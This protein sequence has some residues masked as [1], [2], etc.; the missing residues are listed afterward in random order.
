MG[1][2]S[3]GAWSDLASGRELS[4]EFRRRRPGLPIII[5]SGYTGG[6]Y[7]ALEALPLG[8]GYLEKPFSLADMRQR[9][10]ESLDERAADQSS[11]PCRMSA[12]TLK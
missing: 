1:S 5:G 7:P 10:R 12:A 3:T 9:V 2:R 11:V 6:T 8:I 4:A